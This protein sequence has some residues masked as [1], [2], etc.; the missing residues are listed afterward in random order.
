MSIHAVI[1]DRSRL[2]QTPPTRVEA[3]YKRL[4]LS[5]SDIRETGRI[6]AV[7]S[8]ALHELAHDL[9][10]AHRNIPAPP[11]A[12]TTAT[13]DDNEMLNRENL[14]L[15]REKDAQNVM[16]ESLVILLKESQQHV[17]LVGSDLN[18][19]IE[20]AIKTADI[21]LGKVIPPK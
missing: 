13:Q 5:I 6:S 11:P 19:R 20:G 18:D 14:R 9:D 7:E 8:R 4:Q 2:S 10:D 16:I 1:G 12:P 15:L 21:H 17:P 3:I